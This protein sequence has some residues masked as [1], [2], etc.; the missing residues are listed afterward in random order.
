MRVSVA[1]DSKSVHWQDAEANAFAIEL[2]ILCQEI[3]TTPH[4]DPPP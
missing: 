1:I 4:P 3:L 2:L